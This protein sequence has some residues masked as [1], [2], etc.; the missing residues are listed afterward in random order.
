MYSVGWYL[1]VIPKRK[2]RAL[3]EVCAR[4]SNTLVLELDFK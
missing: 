2:C 3:V 4:L 1:C